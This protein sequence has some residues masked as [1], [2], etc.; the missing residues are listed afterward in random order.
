[1]SSISETLF[2]SGLCPTRV[3]QTINVNSQIAT[4]INTYSDGS[5]VYSAYTYTDSL[6]VEPLVTSYGLTTQ[7]SYTAPV[8]T[9]TSNATAYSIT[10]GN[11]VMGSTSNIAANTVT[12]AF[13]AGTIITPSVSGVTGTFIPATLTPAAGS[14]SVLFTFTPTSSGTA[15]FSFTNNV[16]MNDP[17]PIGR[18]SSPIVVWQNMLLGATNANGAITIPNI[19]HAGGVGLLPADFTEILLPCDEGVSLSDLTIAINATSDFSQ[20]YANSGASFN[21][22]FNL[23]SGVSATGTGKVDS[24]SFPIIYIP[25]LTLPSNSIISFLRV[26]TNLLVRYT[27]DNLTYTLLG[28]I[29]V[30]VGVV[31]GQQMFVSI[32][33]TDDTTG[34][35]VAG[36][37]GIATV[38]LTIKI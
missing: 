19:T 28:T 30:F 36:S 38:N 13:L 21:M 10:V 17:K 29:P 15:V 26:G 2:S 16:A 14:T 34:N 5:K 8:P 4:A 1:M 37:G 25:G 12:G 32:T 33:K 11:M 9:F 31:V 18:T 6:A 27:M 3:E 22:R 20:V 35:G 7:A 23:N 24:S